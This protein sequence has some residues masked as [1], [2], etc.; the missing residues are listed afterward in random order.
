MPAHAK[1]LIFCPTARLEPETVNAIFN[2]TGVQFR[3]TL[4]TF[5]NPYP[6][7][8]MEALKNIEYNYEK[9]RRIALAE[10]YEKVWIVESDIIPPHDALA[11]LLEVKAPVVGGMYALRHGAYPP[12]FFKNSPS[13]V[14]DE[15]MKWPEIFASKKPII[16]TSGVCMGCLLVDR[17]VLEE[18]PFTLP[19]TDYH[20]P[21]IP[22]MQYCCAHGI[23][24]IGRIDVSCGHKKPS[25]E[26]IYPD[27][28]SK[29]GVRVE[30][31]RIAV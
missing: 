9:M 6:F 11:K 15:L 23:K 26:I 2:Q 25:G 20:A 10:G 29:T 17:S 19:R 1:I 13:L 30:M 4:F 14:T 18:I 5:D 12:N 8:K 27:A 31:G 16:E 22:M 3:D 24:Q 21:D 7:V 28:I